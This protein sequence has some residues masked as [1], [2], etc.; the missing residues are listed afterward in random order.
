MDCRLWWDQLDF[1]FKTGMRNEFIY[2]RQTG[3]ST[4][5]VNSLD[6]EESPRKGPHHKKFSPWEYNNVFKCKSTRLLCSVKMKMMRL[7]HLQNWMWLIGSC[8]RLRS[9]SCC[10]HHYLV[11]CLPQHLSAFRH[12]LET[13]SPRLKVETVSIVSISVTGKRVQ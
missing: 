9:R 12:S 5:P 7:K 10:I 4:H 6:I 1:N 2:G 3:H 11:G 8:K 13:H